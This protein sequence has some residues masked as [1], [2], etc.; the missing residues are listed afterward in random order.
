MGRAETTKTPNKGGV[1][2][3]YKYKPPYVDTFHRLLSK[4]NKW[5]KCRIKKGENPSETLN[6]KM[7]MYIFIKRTVLEFSEMESYITSNFKCALIMF[8]LSKGDQITVTNSISSY[9]CVFPLWSLYTKYLQNKYSGEVTND[10]NNDYSKEVV[11]GMNRVISLFRKNH[12]D[13]KIFNE[14]ELATEK[15]SYKEKGPKIYIYDNCTS[16]SFYW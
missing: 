14:N 10:G 4:K 1:K 11:V 13:W 12:P 3:P 15:W 6:W 7:A 2:R 5:I 16:W 9:N 8:D